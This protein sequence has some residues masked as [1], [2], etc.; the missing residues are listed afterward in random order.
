MRRQTITR[1]GNRTPQSYGHIPHTNLSRRRIMKNQN[2]IRA[3]LRSCLLALMALAVTQDGRGIASTTTSN[4]FAPAR[5]DRNVAKGLRAAAARKG[6]ASTKVISSN[7][8][9]SLALFDDANDF[10]VDVVERGVEVGVLH[11]GSG[12]K[13]LPS[14]YYTVKLYASAV[15][16]K[17]ESALIDNKGVSRKIISQPGVMFVKQGDREVLNTIRL[18]SDIVRA[19][20]KSVFNISNLSSDYYPTQHDCEWDGCSCNGQPCGC[21]T[22][23]WKGDWVKEVR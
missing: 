16:A 11:V 10:A 7:G 17:Y 23:V 3:A 14:G 2:L 18:R 5:L 20:G 8:K 19:V 12:S 22:C 6:K 9:V 15:G 4:R 21:R 1:H 13:G